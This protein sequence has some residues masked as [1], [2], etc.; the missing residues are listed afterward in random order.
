MSDKPSRKGEK[1]QSY[2]QSFQSQTFFEPPF[3]AIKTELHTIVDKLQ[4]DEPSGE[5]PRRPLWQRVLVWQIPI[6]LVAFLVVLSYN[7]RVYNCGGVKINYKSQTLCIANDNDFFIFVEHF[8][9]D[10]IEKG[11]IMNDSIKMDSVASQVFDSYYSKHNIFIKDL[12]TEKEILTSMRNAHY[13]TT[14]FCHNVAVAYWNAGVRLLNEGKT[15]SACGYFNKLEQ[16]KGADSVLTAADRTVITRNCFGDFPSSNQIVIPPKNEAKPR[17]RVPTRQ[18]PNTKQPNAPQVNLKIPTVTPSVTLGKKPDLQPIEQPNRQNPPNTAQQTPF[19]NTKQNTGKEP[20]TGIIDP[21]Q[22]TLDPFNGQMVLVDGG[23]FRM[24]CEN[25][26]DGFCLDNALPVHGVTLSNFSIGKYEVTQK[27]WREVMGTDPNNNKKCDNCPVE[28]VS[29]NDIQ[30]FLVKLNALT[31]K[32]YRLPTEAEW[33]YAAR[34]GK[35]SRSFAYSGSNRVDEVAWY[36]SNSNGKTYSVGQK[37]A[38]ELGIFDMSGNVSEY[39][40]DFYDPN[41]YKDSVE[42][43]PRGPQKGSS[44][45]LRGGSWFNEGSYCL[46]S[47]RISNSGGDFN[48]GFRLAIGSD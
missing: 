8:A 29:W 24:G 45:V 36:K 19:D 1:S 46:N 31:K 40:Q 4:L 6:W 25:K 13:D 48:F 39:C 37:K 11:A 35:A 42:R 14:S 32:N 38:N 12:T 27:Q 43:N 10:F 33:E 9:C 2:Q 18:Q 21:K 41:Y 47:Y 15:D 7:P 34:G 30:A 44:Y 20:Q 17:V 23:T 26:K 16:W 5:P 22:Q 3:E 28:S